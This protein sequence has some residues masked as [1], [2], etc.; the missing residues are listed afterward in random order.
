MAV[1]LRIPHPAMHYKKTCGGQSAQPKTFCRLKLQ[2]EIMVKWALNV[3][4]N[5]TLTPSPEAAKQKLKA[6]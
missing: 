2:T 6:S 5:R 4:P 1:T 3:L